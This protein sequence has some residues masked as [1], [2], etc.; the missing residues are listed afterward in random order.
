MKY[1]A[2]T[3]V[4]LATLGLAVGYALRSQWNWAA[5]IVLL[6]LLWSVDQWR[7]W[8]RVTA[9]GLSAFVALA[10]YGVWQGMAAG[11]MLFCTVA[12][13]AA[14]DLDDF[15]RRWRRPARIT[16]EIELRQAHFQRLLIVTGLGFVLGGIALSVQL[17]LTL[18][19]SMLL[20][21]LAVLGL[22][23]AISYLRRESD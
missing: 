18:G 20:G 19:W 3:A 12:A 7:D 17:E 22:S 10:A 23:W 6:G 13:L 14:W 4:S 15:A 11:W 21:L 5:A 8:D 2:L 1:V 9:L 16:E